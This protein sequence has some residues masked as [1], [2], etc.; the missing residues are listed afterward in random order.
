MDRLRVPAPVGLWLLLLAGHGF[1]AALP[2]PAD[3]EIPARAAAALLAG[4]SLLASAFA[5]RF[6]ARVFALVALRRAEVFFGALAL[7]AAGASLAGE[8]D[9]CAEPLPVHPR[10]VAVEVEGPLLDCVPADGANPAL[11]LEARRVRI[12]DQARPCRARLLLRWQEGGAAPEWATPGL[13]IRA[14]GEYRPPED[15]RNPGSQAPGRWLERLGLAGTVDVDP[16]SVSVLASPA[17]SGV[18]WGALLRWRVARLLSHDLSPPVAALARGMILGDR[19]GIAPSIRDAFRDGGT[20]HILSISGLHVCVLAGIVAAAALA[21]RIPPVPAAAIEL[22]A[23]W[24]Y[25]LLV[26]APASAAR[27]AILWTAL[28]AARLR[29]CASRPFAAWG[30]AG[31]LL[32]LLDPTVLADPGF[33]LSFAAVLGLAASG[34]VGSPFALRPMRALLSVGKQSAFAEAGTLGI[35]VTQFGAIPIAGLVLNLLVI[36]LCAWF[37]AALLLHLG[38][39]LLGPPWSAPAAGAVELSGLLMLGATR[40]FARVCPPLPARAVPP[41][42]AVVLALLALAFAA[43]AWERARLVRSRSNRALARAAAVLAL[44]LAWGIPFLPRVEAAPPRA[45]LIL[46]ALDVG[47]GDA[48]LARAGTAAILVDAG[49][50]TA[51]RDEGRITVEP[52]LRAEGMTRLDLALLSHAHR[53]HY[54]GLGWIARRGFVG[55]WVENGSDRAGA[56]RAPIEEGLRRNGGRAAALARDTTIAVGSATL[57][58]LARPRALAEAGSRNAQENNR[59]LVGI[60]ERGG[61]AVCL[62]GDV[63]RGAEEAL[64]Q[65]LGPVDVLKVPHHGSRTSSEPAWVDSLRPAIAIVS[66][67]E[68]NRFGH[69]DRATIGRYLLAG[70]RVFRTDRE[71][72]IRITAMPEGALVSTRAHPEPEWIRWRRPRDP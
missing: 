15:A 19:T 28:R 42:A 36:P 46:T 63:E 4:A 14:R 2:F 41:P 23:L 26:G 47:Q 40:A 37:M 56:W 10:R 45:P 6:R 22:I 12:G 38:T 71:G 72:A 51:S 66:C 16:S 62:A 57:R 49:P 33:Q 64:L 48:L 52:A 59:S 54:G 8:A 44:S 9:G 30:L 58:V 20:I 17:A 3:L 50:E 43:C 69:P 34:G 32:H 7:V 68:R 21:F 65:E 70:T 13:W 18:A 31:L 11:T 29:G 5:A 25:V 27:S 55:V 35:Q 53:D 60:L 61:V 39:A 1:V 67:G 24:G